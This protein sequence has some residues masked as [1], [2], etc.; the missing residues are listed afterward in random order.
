MTSEKSHIQRL[1]EILIEINGETCAL[2][3]MLDY[4]LRQSEELF[5]ALCN[6][7]EERDNWFG[8]GRLRWS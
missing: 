7:K 2:T 4:R 5:S 8:N 3:G 1:S 6:K